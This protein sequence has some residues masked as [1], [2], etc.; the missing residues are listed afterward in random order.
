[1]PSQT[2]F[3]EE[4]AVTLSETRAFRVRSVAA[5]AEYE[6]HIAHPLPPVFATSAPAAWTPLY[7]LDGDLFFGLA[8][9]MTRLMRQLFQE[10]PP[11]LVVGIGYGTNDARVQGETRNRDFTPT[12]DRRLAA[13]ATRFGAGHAPVL[14]KDR[15]AGR[16]AQFLDFIT[17]EL[18]PFIAERYGVAAGEGTVFGSSMGGL[19]AAW[20][21][22]TRSE[23]FRSYVIASPA[24]WWD[25]ELLFRLEAPPR[26]RTTR[27]Y[28]GVGGLEEG[29]GIPGLD[30][31]KLITNARRLAE[32]LSTLAATHPDVAFEVLPGETH[33]SVVPAVLTRGLRAVLRATRT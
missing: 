23:T 19:F 3:T 30:E 22:L 12:V 17:G 29:A 8:T 15:R 5:D 7:V 16:A 33:T 32:R 10:L 26:T 13:M 2:R 28:I 31:W 25:D 14:P 18:Q 27:A 24:S 11:V 20:T 6:I 21:L 9:E 4:G 1:M